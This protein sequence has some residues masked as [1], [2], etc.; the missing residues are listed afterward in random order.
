MIIMKLSLR[1]AR[2]FAHDT[3]GATAI[4][5]GLIVALIV[6]GLITAVASVGTGTSGKW[7]GASEDIGAAHESAGI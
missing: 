1:H 4:E 6:V 7:N 3:K 2:K 5:Y